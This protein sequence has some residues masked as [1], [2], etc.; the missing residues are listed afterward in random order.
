MDNAVLPV[1]TLTGTS[2]VCS[3]KEIGSDFQFPFRALAGPRFEGLRVEAGVETAYLASGRDAL[4]WIVLSLSIQPGSRVLL[5]SYLCDEVIAPFLAHDLDVEFYGVTRDLRVDATD[6]GNRLTSGTRA[7]LYIHYF[8]FETD[9]PWKLVASMAPRAVVIED[10]SHSCL[11]RFGDSQARG[12]IWFASYRKLL[13]LPD[14]AVV[15]WA[16]RGPRVV[17]PS[18]TR[19]SLGYVAA[20]GYRC[21]GAMFKSLWL[22]RPGLFPKRVFRQF[23]L[24]SKRRLERYPK[25]APMSIVSRGLL[26]RMDIGRI[27]ETRRRNFN[28]LLSALGDSED[29]RP[30]YSSLPEGIC[31]L[32]FPVLAED[33]PRLMQHLIEN[34]VY[35]P[36]HWE[37]PDAVSRKEFAD[38]WHVSDRILTLPVDQRYNEAD[39]AR[40]AG[41]VRNFRSQKVLWPAG[42]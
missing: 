8:G 28:H 17:Q 1:Q 6:L 29:V 11:S 39:M 38:A 33:R 30:L 32:G 25:P 36:V 20:V 12:D 7:V 4:H 35:P 2:G 21:I 42:R 26:K 24:W 23:F 16:A 9:F 27:V 37:L 10:A 34:K 31:P 14:G 13:P 40:I 5:P 3:M 41:L 19:V 18:K 15:G 22:L